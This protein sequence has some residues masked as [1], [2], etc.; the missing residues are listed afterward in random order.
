MGIIVVKSSGEYKL[1]KTGFSC[2][3]STVEAPE[4]DVKCPQS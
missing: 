4:L 2:S 1:K 3:E